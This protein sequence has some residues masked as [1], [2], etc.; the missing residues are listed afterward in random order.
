MYMYHT[1]L[2]ANNK[3]SD[4]TVQMR[5]LICAFVVRLWHKQVFSCCGSF[6]IHFKTFMVADNGNK[7]LEEILHSATCCMQQ[8]DS[9][10]QVSR[11]NFFIH[12]E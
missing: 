6:V 5:M 2:P 7:C 10:S 8:H 9:G 4:Q 3:G 11:V 1:I 12:T